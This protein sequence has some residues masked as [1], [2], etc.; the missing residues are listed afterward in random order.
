M[1]VIDILIE[2]IGIWGLVGLFQKY[3]QNITKLCELIPIEMKKSRN[4]CCKCYQLFNTHSCAKFDV[5][6]QKIKY[7]Y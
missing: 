7:I 1:L 4:K 6:H 3:L 5:Q 2:I